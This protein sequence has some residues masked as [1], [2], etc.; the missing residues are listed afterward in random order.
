MPERSIVRVRCT[1]LHA[2]RAKLN[3]HMYIKTYVYEHI[4][5]SMWAVNDRPY[6]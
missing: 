2:L 3:T 6:F 5:S 4:N 1:R